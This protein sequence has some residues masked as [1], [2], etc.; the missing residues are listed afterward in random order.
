ML[1]IIFGALLYS[2]MKKK[3]FF[4]PF[5]TYKVPRSFLFRNLSLV[6]IL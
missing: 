6:E 4:P 2:D 1:H 5:Q 3:F